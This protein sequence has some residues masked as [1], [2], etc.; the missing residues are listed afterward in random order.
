M[1][2]EKE[3]ELIQ[4]RRIGYSYSTIRTLSLIANYYTLCLEYLEGIRKCLAEVK[5]ID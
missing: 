4:G 2:K 3:E 1:K 5:L